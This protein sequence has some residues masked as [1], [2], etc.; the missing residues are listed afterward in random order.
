MF[1]LPLMTLYRFLQPIQRL[2]SI[3]H[4]QR[5]AADV[6]GFA[7]ERSVRTPLVQFSAKSYTKPVPY[8]IVLIMSPWNY[9]VQKFAEHDA[10]CRQ[11]DFGGAV[12]NAG[13]LPTQL[14]RHRR[15]MLSGLPHH[16]LTH[17]LTA[18]K[19]DIIKGLL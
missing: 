6:K 1:Y 5:S 12:H 17:R 4:I 18:G 2:Y 3:I 14:Q 16:F 10:F 9:P 8:G 11:L 13:T 7:R 19:K 15:Q